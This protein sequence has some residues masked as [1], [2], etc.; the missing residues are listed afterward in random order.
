MTHDDVHNSVVTF[1]EIIDEVNVLI[2]CVKSKRKLAADR[3][4]TLNL[5]VLTFRHCCLSSSSL[6]IFCS[7]EVI[8]FLSAEKG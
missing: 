7:H 4:S 5:S 2:L 1:G 6:M 3:S 8:L